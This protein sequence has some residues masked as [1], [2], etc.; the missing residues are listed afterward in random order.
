MPSR[1]TPS[2]LSIG[3]DM[4]GTTVKYG[5]VRGHEIID[6]REPLPT[7]AFKGPKP[8]LKELTVQI[9][10]LQKKHK[11]IAAVGMGVPGFADITR[12]YVHEL[13]NVPGWN[14]VHAGRI[15]RDGTG[16][17][18]FI[19]SD[20]NAMCY[21]EFV[22]GAGRGAVNMIGVTLGTGVGGGL[23]LNRALYR[24]TNYGAGEIG[25]MGIHF[26]G[27][28]GEHGNI[29]AL[30]KYVGNREVT[31]RARELYAKARCRV[32]SEDCEPRALSAAARRGDPVAIQV[33]DEFTTNLAAGL[34]SVVWLLN[35]DRIVIGGGIARAGSV[36]FGPLKKKMFAQLA[37]PFRSKLK[38]V[39]AKFGN[40][41]GIIGSAAVA[42]DLA[43][44][45]GR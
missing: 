18:S 9:L 17:P 35:P 1:T 6:E 11:G 21:A 13:S 12:G 38:I 37:P 8:L 29:G 26:R 15:L 31:A 2:S 32:A 23:V 33:W 27:H 34:S 43:Q 14:R 42:L 36:V 22:H 39:P 3:I 24:G 41:A 7:P 19:E 16:L 5:V 10:A 40:D 45:K 28:M 30:E 20:A 44:R 4:G 25:Q